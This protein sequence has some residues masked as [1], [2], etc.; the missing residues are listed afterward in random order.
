MEVGAR[1]VGEFVLDFTDQE[2]SM[3][4]SSTAQPYISTYDL[5]RHRDLRSW[6][7]KSKST[8]GRN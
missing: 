2:L 6:E 3:A 7:N 5:R 1:G 8:Y 4:I